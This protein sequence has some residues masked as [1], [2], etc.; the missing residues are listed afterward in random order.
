MPD[1]TRHW[2]VFA[3][4]SEGER[5]F[6]GWLVEP[7]GATRDVRLDFLVKL[8]FAVERNR[9]LAAE[10]VTRQ[11]AAIGVR[12]ATLQQQRAAD[13][14]VHPLGPRRLALDHRLLQ[15]EATLAWLTGLTTT[16]SLADD[17]SAS[18]AQ[19]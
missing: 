5:A 2:R 9:T 18:S 12:L 15:T 4:T 8:A 7:V 10:L 19:A 16:L 1:G 13:E 17:S 14:S 11:R 6:D 3:P